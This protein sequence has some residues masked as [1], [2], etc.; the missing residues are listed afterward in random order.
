MANKPKCMLQIRRILQLASSGES[1]R[2]INRI[3]GIHRDTI[4]NYLNLC[5]SSGESYESLLNLK[6]AELAG[7]VFPEKE[8]EEPDGRLKDFLQKAG[9]YK[10]ALSNCR[11]M[12]RKRL[13]EKH[14]TSYP[15][16][17]S[18]SQFC[19]HFARYLNTSDPTMVISHQ[20]GDE[21]QI[22]FAGKSLSYIDRVTGEI[23]F[24]PT[25][26]CSLPYSSLSYLE[27]LESSR[28]E[29]L[30]GG[31]NRAANYLGGI[32][33]WVLSDNMR[34]I[35]T[36]ACR[37]E[38]TFTE[39]SEQ[40]AVYNSTFFKATRVRKPKDKP[41]VEKAVDLGYQNIYAAL[42]EEDIYSLGEL[43]HRVFELNDEFNHRPMYKNLP[44][45]MERFV[46]EEK[47]FLRDLP[48]EPFVMKHRAKAKVK[49]NYHVILG[50]DWH[51]YSVPY[52]YIGKETALIYD[53]VEVEVYF[54]F[55]RIAVHKRDYQRNGYTTLKEHMP[56][57]HKRYHEQRGWTRDDFIEKASKIGEHTTM[58]IDRILQ[59]R[60]F[61][62][63]TYDACQGILRLA[64]KYGSDRLEAACR[65][66]NRGSK[67]TY[68]T[69][70]TILENNQDKVP[71]IEQN[72][73]LPLLP[74]HENIR[75]PE[76]YK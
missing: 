60:T 43:R 10:L 2:G 21:L 58:I 47:S 62:E 68:T 28:L 64:D 7:F 44:S 8:P 51:Q 52:Q 3:T 66:A 29:H 39:L 45:R 31:L 27:P 11:G 1:L 59:S 34:Q 17:Y 14:I 63:Q 69:I 30:V 23:I 53:A 50:E 74:T 40:W 19:E 20:P 71:T 13:W 6:D 12:T 37:Y 18:Y 54:G 46:K 73:R 75:G 16:S 4:T 33:K 56:E 67:L 76:S 70:R 42:Y 72:L 48:S 24:C 15:D 38:P 61:I 32:T 55:K 57:S 35:V 25:L 22:D 41:T 5:R 9:Q 36:R 26:V 65:R 49:R